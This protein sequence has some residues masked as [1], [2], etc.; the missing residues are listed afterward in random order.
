MKQVSRTFFTKVRRRKGRMEE[1]EFCWGHERPP[2]RNASG[3]LNCSSGKRATE[4]LG[5]LEYAQQEGTKVQWG[6]GTGIWG[7]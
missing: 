4:Q 2:G 5:S 7:Q 6:R 1:N 3:P